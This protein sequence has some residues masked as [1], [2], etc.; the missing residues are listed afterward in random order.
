MRATSPVAILTI[1]G[2]VLPDERLTV[3]QAH[4]ANIR[5]QPIDSENEI[6]S[7]GGNVDFGVSNI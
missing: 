2:H 4:D 7:F 5:N 3:T 1:A 6:C